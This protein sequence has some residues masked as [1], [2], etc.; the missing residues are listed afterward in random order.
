MER[1]ILN[2]VGVLA[3]LAAVIYLVKKL[4][5][6]TDTK[7]YSDEAFNVLQNKDKRKQLDQAISEYQKNGKWGDTLIN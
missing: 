1:K 3:L 2:I 7:L 6:S 5:K 4:T